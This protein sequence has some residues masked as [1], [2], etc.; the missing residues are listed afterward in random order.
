M[1]YFH[2]LFNA[3]DTFSWFLL[4]GLFAGLSLVSFLGQ[5][6]W[7][8]WHRKDASLDDELKIILG[9]TLSLF[10][11]LVGFILSFAISGY[12]ARIA[13]EE[14]E[15]IAIGNAFQR[16]TLLEVK[17]QAQ[18]KHLLQE[19]LQLRTQFFTTKNE[20]ERSKVRIDSIQTQTHM[21]QLISK[22]ATQQPDAVIV[23]VL[24][25]CN[26]LYTAQQK[27]MSSWRH[28]IPSAAWALLVFFAICSNFLIGCTIRGHNNRHVL[29]LIIPAVIALTLFMIAEIDVPGKGLIHVTPNNLTSIMTTI[30]SGG[31]VP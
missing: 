23:S 10:G 25:A 1:T 18:A 21:W 5:R 29:V 31:L 24:N 19:Y 16:T 20:L 14:N 11:L 27:T 12:N 26:D 22:L 13:A 7:T 9:A 28:Q 17:H 4:V 15:A 3:I 30:S 6:T 2:E 8:Y